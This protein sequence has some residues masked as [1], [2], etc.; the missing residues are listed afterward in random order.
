MPLTT[1]DADT[2]AF[3]LSA[4]QVP[5]EAVSDSVIAA[6][7]ATVGDPE[8]RPASGRGLTVIVWEA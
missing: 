4:L 2:V 3:A 1:P 5:P 8:I 7:T 6:P